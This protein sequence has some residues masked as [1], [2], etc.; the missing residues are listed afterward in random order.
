MFVAKNN[1]EKEPWRP[2]YALNKRAVSVEHLLRGEPALEADPA[3]QIGPV[4]NPDFDLIESADRFTL[5]GDLPGLGIDDLDIE[6]MAGTLTITGERNPES[7]DPCQ[8]CAALERRFGS[9]LRT[10]HLPGQVLWERCA[11]QMHNGVLRLELPKLPAAAPDG[12]ARRP[13]MDV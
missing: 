9:F 12:R 4:Y 1:F 10:F 5:L 2:E 7:L 8:S 13:A 11:K 3:G 6:F